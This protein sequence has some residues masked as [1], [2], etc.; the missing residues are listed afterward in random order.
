MV[1]VRHGAISQVHDQPALKKR[2]I[3]LPLDED[4]FPRFQCLGAKKERCLSGDGQFRRG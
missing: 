4:L 1:R 3:A 2:V